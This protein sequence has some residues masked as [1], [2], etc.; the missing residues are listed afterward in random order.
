M[1]TT[2][3]KRVSVK[4]F[5]KNISFHL[6][7]LPIEITNHNKYVATIIFSPENNVEIKSVHNLDKIAKVID[8]SVHIPNTRSTYGCGC[9]RGDSR[10]CQKHSRL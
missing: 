2:Q 8:K 6:S 4:E 5:R 7:T 10:L 1:Q 9:E 3:I